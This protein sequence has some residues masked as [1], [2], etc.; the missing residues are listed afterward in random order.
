MSE[1]TTSPSPEGENLR[2]YSAWFGFATREVRPGRT[3]RIR[4]RW[5]RVAAFMFIL[6]CAGWFAKSW[7]LYLFFRNVRNFEDVSFTDMILF[8]MNRE[9]V[10]IQQGDYQIEQARNAMEREDYRRAFSLL[11]EGVARSKKNTEG[12]MLL[13]QIYAGWRP[14]LAIDLLVDGLEHGL[15]DIEYLRLLNTL[16]LMQKEDDRIL[17][18][19]EDLLAGELTDQARQ[20]LSVSRL[21]AA[22][23]HGRYDIARTLFEETNLKSSL[24][25]LILGTQLYARTGRESDAIEVL[26]VALASI[27]KE[28]ASTLYNQLVSIY[29]NEGMMDKARESAL[30]LM[31]D[32]P[33]KW[34]P[35]ILLIDVLSASGM[36]ERRDKEIESILKEFR[37]D[38]RAMSGLAQLS[39]DYGN[40]EAASRLYEVALESGYN[41]SLFSLTLAEAL[42]QAGEHGEA[43][44]LCNEL[45]R[46][47]PAWMLRSEGSFNAIRSLAYFGA[48]DSELGQLYLKNFLESKQTNS[49][50]LFQAAKRYKE[51]GMP[52][53]ALAILEEAYSRDAKNEVVLAN[54]IQVEMDL[55]AFF[56]LDQH[57]KAL[58]QLRRP[59]YDLIGE[60]HDELQSD[61]FLFTK[62]RSLLLQDLNQI[63][64]EQELMQGW[65]IWEKTDTSGTSDSA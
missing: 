3:I 55:G 37:N 26:S 47:D 1:N 62:D 18:L 2:T 16:L 65:N 60:I 42:V 54:M 35:R 6:G 40:V 14:D 48:G 61:R 45:M 46:E 20:I 7:G 39:A 59:G 17:E 30:K 34:E 33:L 57:L 36:T 5:G 4:I 22:M 63:I 51:V 19:T 58:F 10:R 43:I 28:R 23:N 27:P 12:R 52:D 49:G 64:D 44:S 32:N 41:L 53:Q 29:K 24:D 9:N 50:Q 8:P 11:R 25:G 31:I 15:E 56:S 38:E 13:A 21:Q